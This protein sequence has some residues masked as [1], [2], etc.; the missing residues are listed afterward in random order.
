M[1]S[2][3]QAPTVAW[4][5][6][7]LLLIA[8]GI[9]AL[10]QRERRANPSALSYAPSGTSAFVELLRKNG[11]SVRIT[12]APQPTFAEDELPVAFYV[13][14]DTYQLSATAYEDPRGVHAALRH[15][16]EQGGRLVAFTIN[17][18]FHETSLRVI[19]NPVQL[20]S[21]RG[22][23]Y[24]ISVRTASEAIDYTRAPFASG[25]AVYEYMPSYVAVGRYGEGRLI[26]VGDATFATNRFIDQH[27]NA[28]LALQVLR[29]AAPE[30]ATIVVPEAVIGNVGETGLL[31]EIGAWAVAAWWQ[32][33]I[34]ALVIAYSLGQR[35]GIADDLPRRRQRG[36]RELV[37][38]VIFT[39]KRGRA[40]HAAMRTLY[41]HADHTLRRALRL[42][43]DA[44]D[45]ARNQLLPSSLARALTQVQAASDEQVPESVAVDAAKRLER[46]MSE[47]L[48]ARPTPD[49][50]AKRAGRRL[51]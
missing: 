43:R 48:G 49:R 24:T 28:R 19:D 50:R 30:G 14:P 6:L 22:Q 23:D 7:G 12:R 21:A 40:T 13:T 51:G 38:A 44:P 29:L 10:G 47:F 36:T 25:A 26:N 4:V 34:L 2:I 18:R 8:M 45:G 5:L 27:D 3:G 37:D 32:V 42:P 9:L 20:K 35:F 16:L 46:E 39:Y 31:H 1:R 15:H 41:Q 33:L 11:Y 17:E